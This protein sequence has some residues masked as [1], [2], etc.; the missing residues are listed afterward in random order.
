MTQQSKSVRVAVI[1]AG[2]AG[3]R[4]WPLSRQDRPKQLLA[5]NRP[6]KSMLSEAV[7]RCAALVGV[8]HVYI[9]T[10]KHLVDPICEAEPLFPPENVL[11][12]PDKR[13]TAGALAYT[14]SWLL[15]RYPE[16]GPGGISMAVTT[17]D[18]RIGDEM[19]LLAAM[20]TAMKAAEQ[21]DALVT[22][23]VR[24]ARPE[25]GFGYIE[26]ANEAPVL[27]G[28]GG[29]SVYR[30]AA[31]HEKPDAK[32]ASQFLVSGRHLWNSGMFFW[33]IS[34]FLAELRKVQP[35]LAETVGAM[36][37]AISVNNMEEADR[38]FGTIPS[39]SIDYALMEKSGNVLVVQ[40]DFPWAD[41]GAWN[42]VAAPGDGDAAGNYA[43]GNPVLIDCRNCTV[44]NEPGEDQMAVAVVGMSDAI[45]VAAKDALLVLPR[46]RAQDVR[47]VVE[48]LKRRR[49]AQ[50]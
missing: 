36:A 49:A 35:G 6:G 14:A 33:K 18:H 8:E 20:K 19:L 32:H 30:A 22:C 27:E 21:M 23:G 38:L 16:A 7:E 15:A 2:G 1:M 46:E 29:A 9:I 13:N 39:I 4:F 47:A 50:L 43:V 28:E 26:R 40:G 34:S 5:L 48:E 42:A 44:Y 25:T 24:P 45:V 11:A 3:E 41:V 37:Q 17:A 10:G 31:F 12:E